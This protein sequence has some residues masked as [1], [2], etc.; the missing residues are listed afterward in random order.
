MADTTTTNLSLT[1][2]EVGASS[3]SWGGKI[4]TDLDTLDAI[5]GTGGTA[6]T[7]AAVTVDSLASVGNAV[8]GGVLDQDV[9]STVMHNMTNTGIAAD[10]SWSQRIQDPGGNYE[11]RSTTDAGVTVKNALSLA[12][13]TGDATFAG[14]VS[15]PTKTPASASATGTT[16]TISW[17]ANYIYI[18][19]A[20]DTWKRV[21]IAT[22]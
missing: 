18:C 21:A 14:D 10:L 6:V 20:T 8:I 12:H 7:M 9:A 4:N 19:T 15:V 16:G 11:I 17:D 13:A 5:F 2:P 3:G 22:W 1:K